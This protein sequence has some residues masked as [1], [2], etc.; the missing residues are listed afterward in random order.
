MKSLGL[1]NTSTA[2]GRCV[3]WTLILVRHFL[4]LLGRDPCFDIL[5]VK[6]RSFL[7]FGGSGW[8][9]HKHI[10]FTRSFVQRN[11]VPFMEVDQK[12]CR[13][14]FPLFYEKGF[15]HAA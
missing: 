1:V 14:P 9:C 8:G 7:S 3:Q 11:L 15:Q 6:G 12:P 10:T 2:S 5:L 13:T 4:V